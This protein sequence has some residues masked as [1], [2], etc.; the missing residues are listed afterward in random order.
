MTY[1]IHITKAAERDLERAADYI[2]YTLKNPQAA[3]TLL[4]EAERD[5]NSLAQMP[6]RYALADDKVLAAW[7]IRSVRI[8]KYLVFHVIAKDTRTI[9]IIRFLYGKRDW[10]SLLRN[11]GTEQ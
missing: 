8:K 4:E 6:G 2:A 3:D 10:I 9:H 7:G 1:H 5:I 11:T